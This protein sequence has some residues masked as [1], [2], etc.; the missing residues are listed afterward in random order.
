M[1]ARHGP[2]L[3]KVLK[4]LDKLGKIKLVTFDDDEQTLDGL[5]S[6]YIYATIAQDPYKYGYEAVRTLAMLCR[7]NAYLLPVVGQGSVY[8]GAEAIRKDN[9]SDFRV[10]LKKRQAATGRGA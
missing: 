9:L 8:V 4:G 3:L 10:R 7:G 5:E 6:G 1:N 2:I